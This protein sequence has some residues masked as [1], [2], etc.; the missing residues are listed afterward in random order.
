MAGGKGVP[1]GREALRSGCSVHGVKAG[2]VCD[3]C[4]RQGSL[5]S[6]AVGVR[7]ARRRGGS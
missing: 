7:L 3:G 2:E 4:R 6:R 1:A 5:F